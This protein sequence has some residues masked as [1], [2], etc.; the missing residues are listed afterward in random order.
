MKNIPKAGGWCSIQQG[1][2][3][4]MYMKL[5][6]DLG[7]VGDLF[8]FAR[9]TNEGHCI[10]FIFTAHSQLIALAMTTEATMTIFDFLDELVFILNI[11]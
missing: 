3:T 10:S 8:I 9:R 6:H 2:D 11:A 1:I 4:P 5:S 7:Q